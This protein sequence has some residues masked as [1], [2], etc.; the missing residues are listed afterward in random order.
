MSI[1][2]TLFNSL[3]GSDESTAALL[4]IHAPTVQ[5][6]ALYIPAPAAYASHIKRS[7]WMRS[8]M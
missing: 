4:I 2:D 6:T 7:L 3:S 5:A 1:L 8:T